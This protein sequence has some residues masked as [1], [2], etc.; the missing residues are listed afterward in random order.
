MC[1]SLLNRIKLTAC[2]G[3]L[4]YVN[5][6][7]ALEFEPGIGAGLEYTDNAT[8]TADD[9]LDDLIVVGYIGAR[10]EETEGPVT[11][12]ISAALNHHRYT[13][14]TFEDVRYFNLSATAGWEML[15]D[16]FSWFLGNI[17]RQR[18]I[19]SADPNTP[20]NI[21]DSNIFNFGANIIYPISARQSFTLRPEY[22]NFYYEVQVTDNQQVALQAS[23]IYQVNNVTS[24]GLNASLRTIDYDEP[25]I[26][27]VTFGSLFFTVSGI[28]ARSDYKTNLG[29][30]FVSRAN[31]QSTQEFAGNLDWWVNLTSRSRVRAFIATDLTDTSTSGLNATIDPGL[32]DPND[33]QVTTDVIRNQVMTLGYSRTDGTL[34]SSLTGTYRNLN[35]SESPNDREIGSLNA[36]F[37]YPVT[38]LL[39]SGFYARYSDTDFTDT[40]RND[41]RYT[42]GGN[43]RYQLSR[44]LHS[45]L[46]LKYRKKESTLATENFDELSVFASLTYGFG[47][48]RRPTR[49]GGF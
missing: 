24:A 41:Q 15:K 26:D 33:I 27:D 28:R 2:S 36:V 39:T 19:N 44:K 49:T 22:R 7:S 30:T 38:G 46:D 43:L 34:E 17:Y 5:N 37:N 18:P 23:W 11:A 48:P 21:Q 13:K 29:V 40:N 16:R 45:L 42:V 20:D 4:L 3:L 8:L 14:D 6:I 12:D 10:L 1:R 9:Q 35:Y 31:G 32:G 47:E 25:L